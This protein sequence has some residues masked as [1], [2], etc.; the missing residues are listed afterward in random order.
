MKYIVDVNGERVEV[1]IGPDGVIVDGQHLDCSLSDVEG[2]PIHL[3]SIGREVHRV[4]VARGENR[5]EYDL[6]IN[7]HRFRAE[8]VDER[9]RAI[10]DLTRAESQASG[11]KPLIAPM[12][13]L[14][15]RV[16]VAEGD[17]IQAGQG[18]VV[19]EAMKMENE[20]RAPGPG[21]VSVVRVKPGTAVEKG[22]V[23]V[24]LRAAEPA[25]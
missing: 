18:L 13:G 8:A 14:V 25:T 12:P 2:T 9:M 7:G 16:Q 17:S 10:R 1:V 15:V 24:E 20:L 3:L 22:A 5:G 4:T 23:L 6:W 19:M 21:I 11:P